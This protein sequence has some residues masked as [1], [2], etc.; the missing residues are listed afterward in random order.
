[1]EGE[2][3]AEIRG[4]GWSQEDEARET[5]KWR[6]DPSDVPTGSGRELASW[7]R[8]AFLNGPTTRSCSLSIGQLGALLL[9]GDGL[10]AIT[11]TTPFGR[12]RVDRA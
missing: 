5:E 4:P 1:M 3:M 10:A 9:A 12:L 11:V 6:V 2:R 8:E 7:M